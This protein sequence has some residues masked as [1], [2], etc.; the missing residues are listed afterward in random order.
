MNEEGSRQTFRTLADTRGALLPCRG[1]ETRQFFR[2]QKV[3]TG[4]LKD[5]L[6]GKRPEWRKRLLLAAGG[7]E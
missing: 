5:Q 7:Y 4:C 6:S 2:E 1:V 3:N